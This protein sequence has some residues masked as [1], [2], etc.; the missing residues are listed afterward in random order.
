MTAVVWAR[1]SSRERLLGKGSFRPSKAGDQNY[2][3]VLKQKTKTKTKNTFYFLQSPRRQNIY[4]FTISFWRL[5]KR[6]VSL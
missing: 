4:L 1:S 5:H 6:E 3:M 2:R